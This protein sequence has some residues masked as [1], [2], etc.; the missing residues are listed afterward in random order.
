MGDEQIVLASTPASINSTNRVASWVNPPAMSLN[1]L[2]RCESQEI[3]GSR[4]WT[5]STTRPE[6]RTLP[7]SSTAGPPTPTTYF[8]VQLHP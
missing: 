6:V 5:H 4:R 1:W 2:K 8:E 3:S 7:A